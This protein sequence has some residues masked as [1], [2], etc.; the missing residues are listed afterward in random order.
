MITFVFTDIQGSTQLA[1]TLEEAYSDLLSLYRD[2]IR[3]SVSKHSGRIIDSAGDGF[4]ITFPDPLSAVLAAAEMQMNLSTTRFPHDVEVRVRIGIHSGYAVSSESGYTGL[5]VHKTSRICDAAHGGQILISSDTA[6]LISAALP[7]DY[8][9]NTLG[10]FQ[11]KGF[12]ISEEIFQL[13]IPGLNR[14]FPPLR[15][16]EALPVIAV[17]PFFNKARD[18]QVEY[19]CEG[20]STDIIHA[21]SRVPGLRVVAR[22]ASC[23]I[24]SHEEDILEIG[25][26]LKAN[27]VLY[28]SLLKTA[29]RIDLN[30]ELVDIDLSE[31]LW[32]SHI[33]AGLHDIFSVE[34]QITKNI[35]NSYGVEYQPVSNIRRMERVRPQNI[36]AYDFYLK[37]RRFFYQFSRQ[38]VQFALQMFQ[39]AIHIDPDFALAYAGAA[40]CYSYLHMYEHSS[41]GNRSAADQVSAKAIELCPSSAEAHASRGVALS[42]SGKF[43][44][45][46]A[47]FEKAIALD[48][49]LFEAYF[50]YARVEFAAGNVE[51]AAGLFRD[52]H[53]VR[54]EDYQ[55]L[56]LAAQC[57]ES[58]GLQPRSRELI[59]E[60][61]I[62]VEQQIKLNPGDT[63]ALYLG[64]NGLATLGVKDKALLWLQRALTL[65][66]DDPMVL[67][68]AGC[69]YAL[70]GM[71]DEA[72]ESLERSIDAGLTQKNWFV[73]DLDMDSL[74]QCEKFKELLQKLD[75]REKSM[76]Y[77]ITGS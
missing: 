9:L 59:R 74:R 20:L 4:F 43:S 8:Q 67:Y 17:L 73:H 21:L 40:D 69:V 10:R 57:L 37:G 46:E 54:P 38:S 24:R 16:L 7:S 1:R 52:A 22:S 34:D 25:R 60:G 56:F 32:S 72:F 15:V 76:G 35:A 62:I 48:P 75:E 14:D 55:S 47:C 44:E 26:K 63:R 12:D 53:R 68:N 58:M 19:F 50:L 27:G 64:A 23:A 30:V 31:T 36:E 39:Q 49:Q 51:K 71:Q 45:A 6:R 11:L 61:I 33:E 66:P 70:L 13:D 3:R 5:A 28:G 65:E 41:A 2:A 42:L 77:G 29:D 18:Q